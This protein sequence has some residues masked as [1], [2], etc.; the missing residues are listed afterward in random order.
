[1]SKEQLGA[2]AF[3]VFGI[4]SRI[5]ISNRP[6]PMRDFPSGSCSDASILLGAVLT[7]H[8]FGEIHIVRAERGSPDDNSWTSH[9]WLEVNGDLVDITCSQFSDS[10]AEAIVDESSSFHQTFAV[11]SRTMLT[12]P[13]SWDREPSYLKD[14]FLKIESEL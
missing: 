2:I 11:K 3:Q 9:A 8:G 14:L 5:P 1:M 4:L 7:S 12:F 13:E 6:F 10:P